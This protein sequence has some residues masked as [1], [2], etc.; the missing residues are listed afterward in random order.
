MILAMREVISSTAD[1]K[2]PHQGQEFYELSLFDEAND[3]GTRYRVRQARAEWSEIDGQV[4][5]D[6][7]EV[8]HFWILA[9]EKKRYVNE[10]RLRREGLRPL[11]FGPLLTRTLK[12][13]NGVSRRRFYCRAEP[14]DSRS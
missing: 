12:R 11:G 9:E 1:P 3:L 6:Q 5:W 13:S 4:M 10:T 8:E 14:S 7:E 2:A